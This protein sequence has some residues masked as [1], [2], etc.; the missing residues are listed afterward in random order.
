MSADHDII[1]KALGHVNKLVALLKPLARH[2]RMERC[3]SVP[4]R[5]TVLATLR[6]AQKRNL[7]EH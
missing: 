7:F 1:G 2:R 3:G 6:Y 4:L 5:R